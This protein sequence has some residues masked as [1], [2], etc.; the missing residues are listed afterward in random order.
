MTRAGTVAVV[1]KP[2]AGKSTLLN[3]IIGE[4]LSITSAKPQSTRDRI[5]GIY[6]RGD[7]QMIITDTPGL[8]NPRYALQ[9]AMRSAALQALDDADVIVY[10][11][12]AAGGAPPSLEKATELP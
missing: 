11:A 3:R 9:Q 5:V 8:L 7:V 6:T 12:E 1:G 2:N 4:K 10:L